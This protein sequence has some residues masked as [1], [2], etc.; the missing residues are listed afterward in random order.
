MTIWISLALATIV[1]AGAEQAKLREW[2]DV[3]P[4]EVSVYFADV[5]KAAVWFK[6]VDHKG[7]AQYI[8][9]CY[10]WRSSRDPEFDYSGDF[11]CRLTSA[12]AKEK[13]S[14]VLTDDLRQSRDWQSRGRVLAEELAGKCAE[15]PEYG[16]V[17][18]FRLRKMKIT[19]SFDELEFKDF[20]SPDGR[21]VKRR[22]LQALRFT[23]RI[24]PDSG[25]RSEIAE[26]VPFA[27][28]PAAFPDNRDDLSLNCSVPLKRK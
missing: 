22:E 17:R 4:L 20:Q 25:A 9:Q 7:K 13:Y 15:Y 23:L 12:Y 6:I 26:V 10:N 8:L 5:S 27:Y 19:F 11:E 2:P 21:N 28:P 16:R 3:A 14:T 18:N 24:Q 1:N